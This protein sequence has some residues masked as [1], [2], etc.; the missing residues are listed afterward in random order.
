MAPAPGQGA[1]A[2]EVRARTSTRPTRWRRA[3]RA[4]DHRP[5]RLAVARRA[6]PARAA[7]RPG[8]A[9]PDRRRRPTLADDGRSLRA[10]RRDRPHRRHRDPAPRRGRG[11][12]L[13]RRRAP[14]GRPSASGIGARRDAPATP[15]PPTSPSWAPPD[16]R[17][18]PVLPLVRAG[19]SL[20][21]RPARRPQP[22]GRRAAPPPGPRR[23]S[24]RSSRPC[25]PRTRPSWTTPCWPSESG[26]YGWLALTSAAAVPVL[27]DRAQES[28]GSLTQLL[29]DGHVRVAAVGPGTAR[30]LREAGV[31]PD[32]VPRGQVDRPA[33]WSRRGRAAAEPGPRAVPA[34]RPRRGDDHR[35]AARARLG[36]RRRRRLPDRRRRPR[37]PTTCARPG[38]TAPSARRCSP[39]PAPSASSPRAWAPRPPARC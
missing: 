38:P 7:S 5:T 25:R 33:R 10:R 17:R 37:R 32:L 31:E 12:R 11:S 35:R 39:R 13:G 1:L 27:V 3:L 18:R 19:A 22:R 4:L 30:A 28:A 23:S 21:P 15:A 26:W 6:R 9:A 36:R 20:V 2:V 34:R 16:D 24:C 29:A 14:D 8:C